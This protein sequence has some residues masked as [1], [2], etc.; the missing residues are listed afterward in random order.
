MLLLLILLAEPGPPPAPLPPLA[1]LALF[2]S[3]AG[4]L[5]AVQFADKYLEHLSAQWQ[6]TPWRREWIDDAAWE[7]RCCRC[8]WQTL[9]DAQCEDAVERDR[10]ESL[11]VLRLLLGPAAYHRGEMPPPVPLWR[12]TR[13]EGR[14]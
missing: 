6:L 14:P 10:R 13:I 11:R 2:P 4:A 8:C 3:R 5:D 9:A 1:D 7:A 12:F